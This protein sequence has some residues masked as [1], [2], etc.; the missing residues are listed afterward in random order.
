[1]GIPFLIS[2]LFIMAL[3]VLNIVLRIGSV[4]LVKSRFDEGTSP[5]VKEKS[6]FEKF[7]R[8]HF[9]STELA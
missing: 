3:L 7:G 8:N 2:Q 5:S 6:P 9:E 1:M 4:R